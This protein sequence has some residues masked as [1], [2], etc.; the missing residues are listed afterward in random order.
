[1]VM[2]FDYFSQPQP[3]R[4]AME[5]S[6]ALDEMELYS[7]SIIDPDMMVVF[8]RLFS[9]RRLAAIATARVYVN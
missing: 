4:G 2:M 1:M 5:I 7:E 6:E 9:D 8:R 3:G